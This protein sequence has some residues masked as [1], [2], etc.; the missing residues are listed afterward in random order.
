MRADQQASNT[1]QI[2]EPTL[3][4][5]NKR[6]SWIRGSCLTGAGCIVFFFAGLYFVF[7]LVV[8]SGPAVL[9]EFPD[10][11]P[12]DIPQS[13]PDKL[14]RVT[15]VDATTKS[16]AMWL[17]TAIPE[18]MLAPLLG[19]IDPNAR[20]TETHDSLGRVDFERSIDRSDLLR[21]IAWPIGA[22]NTKTVVA[23]WS[24]INSYPS[25]LAD[26]L[27]R[28]LKQKG[29]TVAEDAHPADNAADFSFNRAD[30]ISGT[31]RAIDLHSD[32]SG[33]EFVELIVNYP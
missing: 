3:K 13:N 16:R 14:I 2:Q 1:V 26:N 7:R 18:I 31:F 5:I 29:F 20:I 23:T 25:I 6:S 22:S 19:E 28:S 4:E 9:S 21:Y 12:R 24:G 10:D 27:E 32:Q 11:F 33:V 30:N 15:Y 17:A 8:G